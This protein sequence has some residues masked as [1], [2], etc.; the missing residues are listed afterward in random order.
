MGSGE[1]ERPKNG[2]LGDQLNIFA[3]IYQPARC[4]LGKSNVNS[5]RDKTRGEL[6]NEMHP[7]HWVNRAFLPGTGAMLVGLALQAASLLLQEHYK[8]RSSQALLFLCCSVLASVQLHAAFL[9]ASWDA[10][11]PSFGVACLRSLGRRLTGVTVALALSVLALVTST[12]NMAVSSDT[13]AYGFIGGVLMV[14]GCVLTGM[15]GASA[16]GSICSSLRQLIQSGMAPPTVRHEPCAL[17]WIRSAD[18]LT[19][20]GDDPSFKYAFPSVASHAS[21][22][23]PATPALQGGV[24]GTSHRLDASSRKVLHPPPSKTRAIA[25]PFELESVHARQ[26]S[27]GKGLGPPIIQPMGSQRMKAP[28]A[29]LAAEVAFGRHASQSKMDGSHHHHNEAHH[30]PSHDSDVLYRKIRR[31]SGGPETPA[32]AGHGV[33]GRDLHAAL[34]AAYNRSYEVASQI[35][36]D[37]SSRENLDGLCEDK[38]GVEVCE[39]GADVG[40]Q[41]RRQEL[42][43]NSGRRNPYLFFD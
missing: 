38:G 24:S 37:N 26:Q 22:P 16:A 3:S 25:S 12:P 8:R 1:K 28:T 29:E 15:Q 18:A 10:T 35:L 40:Q 30:A 20:I 33:Q 19:C 27:G 43:A 6:Q 9:L 39:S 17:R 4:E 32:L 21:P 41:K 23:S 13:H 14:F 34:S 7:K 11:G 31:V 36:T 5:S 2:D 42:G